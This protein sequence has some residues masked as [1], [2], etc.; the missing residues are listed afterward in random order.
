MFMG[1]FIGNVIVATGAGIVTIL[2]FAA[3][4]RMLIWPREQNR[5]HPK[6]RIL[7]ADR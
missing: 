1:P 2:V 4:I 6:Y 7:N 3:A 5:N